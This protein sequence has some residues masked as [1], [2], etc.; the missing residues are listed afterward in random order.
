MKRASICIATYDRPAV[1]AR[2]LESIYRQ[3]LHDV[4]VIVVD[5]G[6]SIPREV[7]AVCHEQYHVNKF[8][9]VRRE[10]SYRNPAVARNLAYRSAEGDVVICQSDDVEHQGNAVEGLLRELQPGTFVIAEVWNVC[11][12]TGEPQPAYK[13][14]WHQLTGPGPPQPPR[15]PN[16]ERPLFFLGALYRSD[17]YAVGGN[18]E[19]FTMPSAEDR[20]FADCLMNGLG[21]QPH[22]TSEVKGHHLHHPRPPDIGRMAA[23]SQVL[24]KY[25]QAE[26]ERTG[27][28]QASGGP[29]PYTSGVS[30]AEV[31]RKIRES[32]E[33]SIE[34]ES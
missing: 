1:L 29:W 24:I 17:L 4:E 22:Y 21:L 11:P 15:S 23:P 6:S 19:E 2:V 32:N 12:K 8:I 26:A 10:P 5:D 3:D 18:D 34:C 31:N 27:V 9:R 28:W 16:P 14:R 30:L 7:H 25:K 13:Q 20:W 33:R